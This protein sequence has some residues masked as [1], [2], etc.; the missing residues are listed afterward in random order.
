MEVSEALKSVENSIRDFLTNIM[1]QEKGSD[2]LTSSGLSEERILQWKERR[3]V[4]KKKQ[5]F[6]SFDDRLLYYSDFYDLANIIDKNWCET[7]KIALGEKK[8]IMVL[9]KILED[10]RNP[11]AHRREFLPHQKHLILGISGEIRNRLV[12]YRSK[13]ETGEDYFPRIES[14]R[15]NLGNT[16]IPGS[17]VIT[18]T[19]ILRPGDELTFVISASDPLGE[20]MEYCIYGKTEWQADYNIILEISDKHI[21]KKVFFLLSIRSHRKYHADDKFDDSVLFE[22]SILPPK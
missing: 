17:G 22:Y 6:G 12:L 7:F 4:E 2:W 18:T 15:D 21:A 13:N 8:V 16:W 1:A 19:N 20:D 11:D 14:V 3:E 10:Y 5:K 9:L